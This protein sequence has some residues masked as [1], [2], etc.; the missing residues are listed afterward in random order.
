[1]VFKYHMLKLLNLFSFQS[2]KKK[3][4][5]QL[6]FVFVKAE[7]LSTFYHSC[8]VLWRISKRKEIRQLITEML[9]ILEQK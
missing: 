5:D 6:N 7:G 9:E 2:G 8:L 4:N 3:E 1:M